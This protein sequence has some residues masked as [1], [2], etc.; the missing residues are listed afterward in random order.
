MQHKSECANGVNYSVMFI[1][2]PH[3]ECLQKEECVSHIFG[4]GD[5]KAV[6]PHEDGY[7]AVSTKRLCRK[8][9][10]SMIAATGVAVFRI[11][12]LQASNLYCTVGGTVHARK[13]SLLKQQ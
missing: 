9:A 3:G 2:C 8:M 7:F 4:N 13:T 12:L 11:V 6:M 5:P 1:F 10:G